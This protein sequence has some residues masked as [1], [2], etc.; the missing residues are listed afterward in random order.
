MDDFDQFWAVWPKRCAKADA[1]KAW[2]QTE[3]VRPPIAD[4]IKA[5]QA[6]CRTEQWMKDNGTYIPYPATWI[7][8][9]RWDD[10][11]EVKLPGVV[12]GK[13]WHETW[14]GIQAKGAELGI[15]ESDFEHPIYFKQAVMRASMKAAA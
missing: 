9:E 14:K 3:K 15:K 2:I 10:E 1:R 5:I 13:E 12:D 7:R 4:I 8:G 11:V 6:Q